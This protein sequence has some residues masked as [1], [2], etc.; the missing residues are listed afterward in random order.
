VRKKY[1]IIVMQFLRESRLHF[2]F[3]A[4]EFMMSFKYYYCKPF[5]HVIYRAQE[6][7]SKEKKSLP[8]AR[9]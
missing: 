9:E 3:F 7:R 4:K 5:C 1:I 8:K 6:E 2:R